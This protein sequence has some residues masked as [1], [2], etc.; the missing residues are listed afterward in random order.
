MDK[1]QPTN[2]GLK[3]PICEN[4]TQMEGLGGRPAPPKAIMGL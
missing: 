3:I 1:K 4:I 2:R